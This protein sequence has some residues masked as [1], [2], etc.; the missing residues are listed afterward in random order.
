MQRFLLSFLVI[1][2][3][4]LAI[5]SFMHGQAE[6]VPSS[7]PVYQF[8]KKMEVRG[9]IH[10]YH[11]AVLPLSRK[12]VGS[13]L[14]D[15]TGVTSLSNAD[16][17]MLEDFL[18]EFQY[19]TEGSL[20]QTVGIFGPE[21]ES[22]SPG[23]AYLHREKFL[24]RTVDS[25]L[26]L[27]VNG[28]VTFDSRFIRGDALGSENT[29]HVQFG[30]RIRGT[31][32]ERLGFLLEGTNAQFWGSRDLL[33]R[34]RIISQSYALG[35]GDSQNFDFTEGY[36]RYDAGVV[37]AQVGRERLLW[38]I[39]YDQKLTLSDNVRVFDFIRADATYK[40]LKY[41]FVHAWLLGKKKFIG[42][43]LPSDTSAIFTEPFVAD[44]YFAAHRLE[45]SLASLFDIGAQ[46]M[47][48][49]SNRAPDL[50]YLNP[51]KVLES[52]QRS[53]EERD[54]V[55]WAFDIQTHFMSGLELSGSVL[56]DD[57]HFSEFFEDKWYNKYAYQ[58]GVFFAQPLVPPD[59]TVQ[60]QYTR[61]EPYVFSH[62]RAR[63]NDFGSLSALLGPRIGPNADSWFVRLDYTP[64]RNL[65]L[66]LRVRTVRSGENVVDASGI[67]IQNVGGDFLQPHRDSDPDTKKF[68]DGVL[69]TGREIEFM[70][71]FELVNQIW[72]ETMLQHE[73]NTSDNS[74]SILRNTTFI[75]RLRLEF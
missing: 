64:L 2:V 65:W 36:V 43:T 20:D 17:G 30:G 61:I 42:F 45:F 33:F 37:S 63:D 47:V 72:L 19:E 13:F 3:F 5:P 49:Y 25:T 27:F 7:H 68:L 69:H 14:S 11:D 35:T 74:S 12:D 60:I 59:V 38:G 73:R 54:N 32:G 1:V 57:I 31:I 48:V 62:G 34:D 24:Y 23:R 51:L 52:A 40:S 41:T 75:S 55:F 16:L 56:F 18:S 46:E 58:V 22:S 50:A 66:S 26:S 21:G 6:T 4:N 9:L 53:R 44:K 8:L 39:G 70:A 28:L 15:L 29:V 71:A 10:R 67:L